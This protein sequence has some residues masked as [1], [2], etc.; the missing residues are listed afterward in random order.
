MK[1]T[2]VAAGARGVSG[3]LGVLG[4]CYVEHG[5]PMTDDTLDCLRVLNHAKEEAEWLDDKAFSKA[6][7][8]AICMAQTIKGEKCTCKTK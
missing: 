5:R 8:N 4:R 6:Y 7:A 2:R 1:R 3:A